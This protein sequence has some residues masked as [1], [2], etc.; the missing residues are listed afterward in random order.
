MPS[1]AGPNVW[2]AL[3]HYPVVNKNGEVV[4]SAVTNLDIHDLARTARTYGVQGYFVVTPLSDQQILAQ[5]IIDHWTAG[6]GGYRHPIR[7]EALSLVKIVDDVEAAV[8][9]VKEDTGHTPKIIVTGARPKEGAIEYEEFRQSMGNGVP[10]LLLFGTAWGL[11]PSLMEASQNALAP[12]KGTG[13]YN[14][15]PVRSAVAIILDRL[16]GDRPKPLVSVG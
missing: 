12:I 7:K 6:P 4:A 5:R 13:D 1:P 14:H 3:I 9:A 2:I 15:L 8:A 10:C 16:L 11:A